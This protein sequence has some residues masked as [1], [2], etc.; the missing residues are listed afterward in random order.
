MAAL[1]P[2][3]V[4]DEAWDTI[5]ALGYDLDNTTLAYPSSGVAAAEWATHKAAG[6]MLAFSTSDTKPRAYVWNGHWTPLK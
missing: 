1:P 2:A 3:G 4:A 6:Y 5:A